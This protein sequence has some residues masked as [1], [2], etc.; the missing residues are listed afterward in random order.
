MGYAQ[1]P[2]A[3]RERSPRSSPELTARRVDLALL[4]ST[5]KKNLPAAWIE[6][7][8]QIIFLVVAKKLCDKK[9]DCVSGTPNQIPPTDE[10]M[11][12]L[13]HSGIYNTQNSQKTLCVRIYIWILW[14]ENVR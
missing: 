7:A 10:I 12:D 3:V 4:I 2:A 5:N 8:A 1:L 11:P 14:C 6:Q 13:N 9:S